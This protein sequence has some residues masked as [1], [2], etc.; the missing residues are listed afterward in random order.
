MGDILIGEKVLFAL[1]QDRPLTVEDVKSLPKLVV[2]LEDVQRYVL[3][4]R[5]NYISKTELGET[6][7]G[8]IAGGKKTK[9]QIFTIFCEVYGNPNERSA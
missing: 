8:Y 3:L 9:E 5:D 4:C 7:F 1:P 2:P 6:L